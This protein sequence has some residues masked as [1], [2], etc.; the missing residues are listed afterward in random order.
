MTRNTFTPDERDIFLMLIEEHKEVLSNNSESVKTN[1]AKKEAWKVVTVA[2][3]REL[4]S[5]G[6]SRSGQFYGNA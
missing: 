3:N 1:N 6:V 4:R 5:S 2:L